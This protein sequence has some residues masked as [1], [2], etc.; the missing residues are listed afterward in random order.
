MSHRF[1]R[2][3]VLI[4]LLFTFL[5]LCLCFGATAENVL[6]L[7]AS[8]TEIEEEAFSGMTEVEDLDFPGGL[9]Q[10]GARA[11]EGCTGLSEIVLPRQLWQIGSGAFSGCAGLRSALIPKS[12]TSIGEN[13]FSGCDDDF[14]ILGY[15]ATRAESYA[16]ENNI[17]FVDLTSFLWEDLGEGRC[18]V[19]GYTGAHTSITI[20]A[21]MPD[22]LRVYQVGNGQTPFA[23]E[24]RLTHVTLSRG[25]Q[26]IEN[27]AF[28]DFGWLTEVAI[29]ESVDQIGSYAFASTALGKV[30]IPNSVTSLGSHAFERCVLLTEAQL[31]SQLEILP[32]SLFYECAALRRISIPASTQIIESDAFYRCTSLTE[33]DIPSSVR[34]IRGGAFWG[35]T[36]LTAV[37][38]HE[39]LDMIDAA[40]FDGCTSLIN[41]S[42]P[43]SVTQIDGNFAVG[44]ENLVS[45]NVSAENTA[46]RSVDGVLYT[47]DTD[48]ATLVACPGSKRSVTVPGTV[49]AIGSRAFNSCKNLSDVT[50]PASVTY[51]EEAAFADCIS[52]TAITL[53]DGINAIGAS[54]FYGCTSLE[55]IHWPA[56]LKRVGIHAFSYCRSLEHITL[57]DGLETIES[58]AF[59]GCTNLTGVT[60]PNGLETIG[61]HAF[62]NCDSLTGI[63]LPDTVVSLGEYAFTGCL[64]LSSAVLSHVRT[65][66]RYAFESCVSLTEIV[67]PNTVT[68]IGARTF[69]NCS[70]LTR[71]TLSESLNAIPDE[72]FY[73]DLALQS[74]TVPRNITY[75]H[76]SAFDPD[77]IS[78]LIIRGYAGSYA[79]QYALQ[80]EII[81]VAL[82]EDKD[83]VFTVREDDTCTLV[84]YTGDESSVIIPAADSTGRPVTGIGDDAFGCCPQVIGITVPDTVQ[85]ISET[86]FSGA[87]SGLVLYGYAGT[88][89]EAF[90]AENEVRF[91]P[92]MP[93]STPV[94]DFTWQDNGDGTCTLLAYQGSETTLN[95]PPTDEEGN[96]L[97]VIGENAFLNYAEL[98]RLILPGTVIRVESHA[99]SGCD[100]LSGIVIPES[101]Q[102]IAEDAFGEP[103]EGLII[104]GYDG[105][106]AQEYAEAREIPFALLQ[107]PGLLRFRELEDGTCALTSYTGGDTE[108]VLPETNEAGL[109]VAVIDTGAFAY[110]TRLT[111]VVLPNSCVRIED[112]AFRGCS[113]LTGVVLTENIREMGLEAFAGCPET[114]I[115][116]GYEGT[117][118]EAY[119]ESLGLRFVSMDPMPQPMNCFYFEDN[120]DGTCTL[121]GYSGYAYEQVIIPR[122][123]GN[124]LLVTG[125]GN[126]AFASSRM[127]EIVMP[128]SILSV[129]SYAFGACSRLTGITLSARLTGIGDE[130]FIWC[131]QL[132]EISL[133]ESVT[134]IGQR[135]FYGCT[136]LSSIVFP[137]N[138][139]EIGE[140]AFYECTSLTSVAFPENLA[141]IGE[142]A[143]SECS[144]LAEAAL[145]E[146]LTVLRDGVFRNDT[147]LT[148]VDLPNMLTAIGKETFSG[149]T[150]LAEVSLPASLTVI[151]DRAFLDCASLAAVTFPSGLTD[152]G[153]DTFRN[154][155]ALETLMLPTNVDT[156]HERTFQGCTGL[157]AVTIPARIRSIYEDAFAGCE[158]LAEIHLSDTVHSISSKAFRDC[159]AGMTIYGNSGTEAQTFAEKNGY[160]FVI[161]NPQNEVFTYLDHCN[162]TAAITGFREENTDAALVIPERLNNGLVI[163]D[164][165]DSAFSSHSELTSVTLPESLESINWYA[166]SGCTGLT[167]INIPVRV[168]WIGYDAF[169]HC[170]GLDAIHVAQ[171]NPYYRSLDGVL[172]S[173]DGTEL[174]ICPPRKTE[175]VVPDGVTTISARFDGC[176]QL[177]GIILPASV[178][179]IS[180]GAIYSLRSDLVIYGYA[181]SY[182][183]TYAE[184]H[185]LSF[186]DLSNIT[187]TDRQDGTCALASCTGNEADLVLPSYSPGGLIVKFIGSGA[188][189]GNTSVVSV[190]IPETVTGIESGA[191]SGCANLA[192]VTIPSGVT[193]IAADCFSGCSQELIIYAHRSSYAEAYALERGIRFVDNT[194]ATPESEFIFY[195]QGDGTCSV[196]NYT[197]ND[198][199]VI[200]PSHHSL[201]GAVVT[202]IRDN[203][204]SD[205]QCTSIRIPGTVTSIGDFAFYHCTGLTELS[206]PE[207]LTSIGEYAFA[208]CSSLSGIEIPQSVTHIGENAFSECRNM[209]GRIILPESMTEIPGGLFCGCR[210]L[211]GVAL[212]GSVVSIGSSAFIGC[213]GL[214]DFTIPD[215]V[216]AIGSSAFYECTGLTEILI[217]DSV[218]ALGNYA[219]YGCTGL[220]SVTLSNSLGAIDDDTFYGCSGLTEISLPAG[221]SAI[222]NNAFY[223]CTSLTG[224][225]VPNNVN[226]IGYNAFYGCTG[227][228]SLTLPETMESLGG[229]AF[230]DC[231]GLTDMTIPDGVTQ[232]QTGLFSGCTSLRSVTI[233][234]S[235]TEIEMWTFTQC[236]S[237]RRVIG[238]SGTCAQTFAQEW[239]YEFINLDQ[240]A[241]PEITGILHGEEINTAFSAAVSVSADAAGLRYVLALVEN[242]EDLLTVTDVWT[243]ASEAAVAIHPVQLQTP[244]TYQLRVK[245]YA[246]ADGT[247]SENDSDWAVYAFELSD[248]AVPECPAVQLY[249]AWFTLQRDQYIG[250]FIPEAEA[251]LWQS[252][253]IDPETGAAVNPSPLADSQRDGSQG[254]IGGFDREGT[255]EVRF[256]ARINGVW[257]RPSNP[258]EITAALPT[259]I[260][261][262]TCGDDVT[263][264]LDVEGTLMISGSGAME[265]FSE[266]G[267]P[268]AAYDHGVEYAEGASCYITTV[269]VHNGV[270]TIGRNAFNDC[271]MYEISLPASILRVEENA[272]MNCRDLES[273][274]YDGTYAAWTNIDIAETGNEYLLAAS[275]YM[276]E[277]PGSGVTWTYDENT[278]TLTFSG[279][280]EMHNGDGEDPEWIDCM[281]T[282]QTVVIGDGII[283]VSDYAFR[284]FTALERVTMADSVR[285]IGS[286]AF[287]GCTSLSSVQL[288]A[289][290]IRI[291][292]NA[293]FN[294][295]A[296]TSVT[297]PASLKIIGDLAFGECVLA[298]IHAAGTARTEAFFYEIESDGQYSMYLY[299]YPVPAGATEI[300]ETAFYHVPGTPVEPYM[301][302]ATDS[303]A[304]AAGAYAGLNAEFVWIP[305]NIES[306]ASGAFANANIQYI[307]IPT[308][309]SLTPDAFPEN[310]TILAGDYSSTIAAFCET[311]GYKYLWLVYPYGG[312]G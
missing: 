300:R 30:V 307:Y 297:L 299:R 109:S 127:T 196:G 292:S 4:C 37:T 177:T 5:F 154:C 163:T 78:H 260:A 150:A 98:A 100:G 25:I 242:G 288:S 7:P 206:L 254:Q 304:I 287:D 111:R 50:L 244:G 19:T 48:W 91:V 51:I 39:G 212:P 199:E 34:L 33:V 92:I 255:Y 207:S 88:A 139:A 75:I 102:F 81:F 120:G 197:G 69:A 58:Y 230:Q 283:N 72:A 28:E 171:E 294:C 250:F 46:Y 6:H 280:G 273:V 2:R 36:A 268:W 141:D 183:E 262:G 187:Y 3:P 132:A 293:F 232:L 190:V 309:C 32:V 130:A 281:N 269:V 45:I 115:L 14:V 148:S 145:P 68:E 54:A 131:S 57:P 234:A 161:I 202:A 310:V 264:A 96:L 220:T 251:V 38:L 291:D 90:A 108:L 71:V 189:R 121:T 209:T 73:G 42:L 140:Y 16:S 312:N 302:P 66:G 53:P 12:V 225:V 201:T 85:Q 160:P 106:C 29:P 11:F 186:V 107:L 267:G 285:R 252:R 167:E 169:N 180:G 65:I 208:S 298:D 10:I 276:D 176:D 41:I 24:A 124:G 123:S 204:F 59:A 214:T 210:G 265:N 193:S 126:S 257:S 146:R 21:T 170:S 245:A 80:H 79:Q 211:S 185:S 156:I 195:D 278:R 67:L 174:V 142:Y 97:T 168:S 219:F 263:W 222:G 301:I 159:P 259:I 296:L 110:N 240:L 271:E 133:P 203:A 26:R 253:Y 62:A 128:D 192:G 49:H 9:K 112:G 249:S 147:A 105:S 18:A 261:S 136:A 305:E 274:T 17:P 226:A 228:L 15:N 303:T 74:V 179:E 103:P 166:F 181:G 52:L 200:I 114:M 235:V 113:A 149:C 155:T 275:L 289:Q 215:S 279:N 43:A 56:G 40:V 247:E 277:D 89:V 95:L 117:W 308:N 184:S 241:L 306:I 218:T 31:P 93:D 172:Y 82:D 272:F 191:F 47:N 63:V 158:S 246:G 144:S 205:R 151:D 20:P 64:R 295:G 119:A 61:V 216:T 22:G 55:S 23:C 223:E 188:F 101:V 217:P 122:H 270:T 231:T 118:A 227:L 165:S 44:C 134:A 224:L 143:F 258:Y 86:A 153:V 233:P 221:I 60:L 238:H 104:Y 173:A 84:L 137:E 13:A 83:F 77:V 194:P 175:L 99:F 243:E 116:Y 135:T 70:R 164:I 213:T 76:D 157:T 286:C 256:W 284:E 1:S 236:S 182:A 162:G 138:L 290:L 282:A 229:S 237:L 311:N 129:G 152:L 27:H 94:S 87:G 8:L 266:S 125:I 35:C 248:A 198:T 178:N 239:G